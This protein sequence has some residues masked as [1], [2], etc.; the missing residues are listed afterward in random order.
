MKQD[1]ETGNREVSTT[2]NNDLNVLLP[3]IISLGLAVGITGPKL[4]KM[5]Q[6][7][8]WIP[9]AILTEKVILE[10]LHETRRQ[11]RRDP[12]TYWL[13]IDDVKI[14]YPGNH[15]IN[16][17]PEMWED[18]SIGDNLEVVQLSKEGNYYLRNGIFVSTGNFIFD[19]FLLS[20]EISV[21][22]LMMKRLLTSKA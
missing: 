2:E 17:T 6:I 22:L 3:L 14:E 8:G 19:F 21:A 10:K 16:L 5:A 20:I 18:L 7:R 15:R 1:N 12:N 4:Y 11:R 13:R 9:G